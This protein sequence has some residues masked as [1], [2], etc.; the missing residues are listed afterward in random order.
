MRPPDRDVAA[1]DRDI[2]SGRQAIG[3]RLVPD[4]GDISL[5]P[6][7]LPALW[8]GALLQIWDD[9]GLY[10]LGRL[11]SCVRM[12][13]KLRAINLPLNEYEVAQAVG[14]WLGDMGFDS[15]VITTSQRGYDIDAHH[16]ATKAR[17]VIEA[18]GGT[19]SK[20][21]TKR[22]GIEVGSAGA[23]F[24]TAAAFHNAV[25]WTGRKALRD[26]N[27]GIALPVTRWFDIH[28][29]KIMPACELLGITVFRVDREGR[30]LIFPKHPDTMITRTIPRPPELLIKATGPNVDHH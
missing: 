22:F 9:R 21:G 30:I 15:K 1:S 13:E 7:E 12:A 24:A 19:S 23:Y 27:I 14:A 16:P 26:A 28:S 11:R 10:Y 8:L 29:E 5:Q 18:K 2:A 25:A 6:D 17:W 3:P 20:P 4:H